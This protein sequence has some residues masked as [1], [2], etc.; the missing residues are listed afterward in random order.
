MS[1][2]QATPILVH[3]LSVSRSQ[4][5]LWLLEELEVPYKVEFHQ[6][7]PEMQAPKELRAVHPIGRSPVIVDGD[8]TLAE[9]G[10][11]IEYII[12][13]YGNGKATP[14]KDG[15]LIDLYFR[16]F[17]EGT[18]MPLL[19]NRFIY[20]IVPQKAPFFLRPLLRSVFSNLDSR[21]IERPMKATLDY[22]ESV[23]AKSGGWFAGGEEPTA[24]DFAMS[25]GLDLMSVK[26]PDSVGPA[27]KAWVA[28]IHERPAYKRVSFC[29]VSIRAINAKL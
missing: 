6:R 3:H 22:T 15:E 13:K 20:S 8:V 1:E 19:G 5:I 2:S 10:A 17:A 28:R 9:S 11:V 18:F 14:P 21:L 27:I 16:H 12:K 7:T 26:A 25:F 4:T 24:A 29:A 23:L